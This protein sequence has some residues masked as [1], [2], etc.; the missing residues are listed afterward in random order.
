MPSFRVMVDV[1][2]ASGRNV[3][4]M[5]VEQALAEAIEGIGEFEAQNEDADEASV[6]NIDGARAIAKGE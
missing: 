4:A 6:Y 3:G 5:E 2:K 1:S